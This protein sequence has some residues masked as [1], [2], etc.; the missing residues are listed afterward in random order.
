[1]ASPFFEV[2][3]DDAIQ[4]I[5]DRLPDSMDR[6]RLATV[7]RHMAAVC[8]TYRLT[9]PCPDPWFFVIPHCMLAAADGMPDFTKQAVWPLTDVAVDSQLML[10]KAKCNGAP[11]AFSVATA[12]VG[13]WS[14]LGTA[15]PQAITRAALSNY[16]LHIEVDLTCVSWHALPFTELCYELFSSTN[17]K[18]PTP[19]RHSDIRRFFRRDVTDADGTQ[20]CTPDT[21]VLFDTRPVF[22]APR[23]LTLRPHQYAALDYLARMERRAARDQPLG[24]FAQWMPVKRGSQTLWLNMMSVADDDD[25][26]TEAAIEVRLRH[27]PDTRIEYTSRMFWLA[28][29]HGLGKTV[30]ML[31]LMLGT[32]PVVDPRDQVQ[33]AVVRATHASLVVVDALMLK[34][35][36]DWRD[37]P[38][39]LYPTSKVYVVTTRQEWQA[40]SRRTIQ[41]ADL[42]VM[43]YD[44]YKKHYRE[45]AE[46]PDPEQCTVL[47]FRWQRVVFDDRAAHM[48]TLLVRLFAEVYYMVQPWPHTEKDLET[49]VGM[50]IRTQGSNDKHW[51]AGHGS[52]SHVTRYIRTACTW[53]RTARS[54]ASEL[55]RPTVWWHP[56]GVP[57]L[58][59]EKYIKSRLSA[60]GNK[61]AYDV[62]VNYMVTSR[63]GHR[64]HCKRTPK[65][66]VAPSL[67]ASHKSFRI[68]FSCCTES[69]WMRAQPAPS[70]AHGGKV[71]M[72]HGSLATTLLLMLRDHWQHKPS[73][74]VLIVCSSLHAVIALGQVLKQQHVPI[75]TIGKDTS[76]L[77][78]TSR[79]LKTLRA[80]GRNTRA[81]AILVQQDQLHVAVNRFRD[82]HHV[83][84]LAKEAP[85]TGAAAL[86]PMIKNSL[87][88][89]V[90]V[91]NDDASHVHVH[92][93][94]PRLEETIPHVDL[95]MDTLV[96]L[97]TH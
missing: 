72:Q 17:T 22:M 94:Y 13:D 33:D 91:D 42:I 82:V 23:T 83:F 40:L 85:G 58:E 80:L 52:W 34:G 55:T 49:T 43:P 78:Y 71:R 44:Y 63:L 28:D 8:H 27:V 30:T 62:P 79:E 12:V 53:R 10:C 20:E 32:G 29:E 88:R 45:A 60:Q 14:F 24:S 76:S 77:A 19:Q 75:R 59:Q 16:A 69:G 31:A 3:Y 39:R 89:P 92:V 47:S 66:T 26:S 18:T 2:L 6:I 7:C 95:D 90:H 38:S 51:N 56:R 50:Q 48:K 67:D 4:A 74:Q 86:T 9:H 64:K 57:L 25:M 93:L 15:C 37:L 1:M 97:P 46:Y 54:V 21:A 36:R 70:P 11:I 87:L 96:L 41:E 65:P 35:N 84:V 5:I 81:M 61:D 68:A 73:K